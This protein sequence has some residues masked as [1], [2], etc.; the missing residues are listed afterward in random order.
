MANATPTNDRLMRLLVY[1]D[2]LKQRLNGPL[3]KNLKE[4]LQIDLRKTE[5]QIAKLR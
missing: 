4:V 2:K 3:D 1:A 5:A